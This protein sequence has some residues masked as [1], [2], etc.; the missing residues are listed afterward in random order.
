M[1]R[2]I[3]TEVHRRLVADCNGHGKRQVLAGGRYWQVAGIGRW[4]ASAERWGR[5]PCA[6]AKP[7][8]GDP[9]MRL[10]GQEPLRRGRATGGWQDLRAV[11]DLRASDGESAPWWQDV[12]AVYSPTALCGAFRIHGTHI[13]P[14][15]AESE[16]MAA[17]CCHEPVFF[18]S[19]APSGTH[20]G[21]ILPR[22][23]ARERIGAISCHGRQLENASGRYL[24]MA[25]RRMS[26]TEVHRRPI[27]DCNGSK[28]LTNRADDR[29]FIPRMRAYSMLFSASIMLIFAR[30]RLESCATI[31]A[32]SSVRPHA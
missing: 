4:R 1:R 30:V 22:P 6:R 2:M 17:I 31:K 7:L 10:L 5:H 19:G 15:L 8:K 26:A 23:A 32:N 20:R 14:K 29:A 18:P 16:Y 12:R 27:S 11:H 24:A 13:L 21:T 3:A 9:A 25:M 28:P